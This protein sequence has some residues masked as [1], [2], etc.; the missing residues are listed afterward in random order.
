MG[1]QQIGECSIKYEQTLKE[2]RKLAMKI[3]IWGEDSREGKPKQGLEVEACLGFRGIAG[4]PE[5][6]EQSEQR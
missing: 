2:V 6:L 4:R 5:G 3:Y 1:M